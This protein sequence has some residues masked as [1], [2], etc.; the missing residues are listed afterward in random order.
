MPQNELPFNLATAEN[1]GSHTAKTLSETASGNHV[2]DYGDHYEAL[3]DATVLMVDDEPTTIEVLQAFLENEG[4]K[5]FITTTESSRAT[6]M[7]VAENPDGFVLD[8][9]LT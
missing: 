7:M 9:P 4:Y 3:R 6:E 1:G 5:R 8:L 2:I